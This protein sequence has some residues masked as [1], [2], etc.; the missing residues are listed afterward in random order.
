MTYT[1]RRLIFLLLA[2]V[3]SCASGCFGITQNPSYFPDIVP[4]GDVVRTHAKP[5]G[6]SY[7]ANFDPHAVDLA[8][9]PAILTSQVGAQVVILATV[10]DEKGVP[11]RNRR[12]DFIVTNGNL[13]EANESGVFNG[14]GDITANRAET[15]TVHHE[16]RISRGNTSQAD[17]IMLRPGQSWCVVSSPVEADTHVQVVVPGI[18]N[19]DKRMKTAVIRWVDATWEFPP[20]GVAK[21][22]TEHEF[23]TRIA[24]HTDRLALANYRVRYKI[25]DGPPAMLLPSRTRKL[26]SPPI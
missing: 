17:D 22:G 16:H 23:V 24:R 11:R 9:E 15:Y 6:P 14:R 12:V 7:Y 26:L 25:L 18:F 8:V 5:I 20:R 19:W 10:R 13:I 2:A 21:F 3:L 4:F 1:G